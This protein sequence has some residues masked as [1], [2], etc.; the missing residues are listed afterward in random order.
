MEKI[1]FSDF[2]WYVSADISLLNR[3][4]I[5]SREARIHSVFLFELVEVVRLSIYYLIGF[6]AI[7][8][9]FVLH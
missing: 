1:I 2:I 8:L 6:F 4:L 7:R 5:G 3:A 9:R